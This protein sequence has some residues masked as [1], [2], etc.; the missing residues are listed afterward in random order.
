VLETSTNL[1]GALHSLHVEHLQVLVQLAV[2]PQSAPALEAEIRKHY[3]A[4]AAAEVDR[5][6]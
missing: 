1:D 3:A 6:T 5:P 2:T 4:R